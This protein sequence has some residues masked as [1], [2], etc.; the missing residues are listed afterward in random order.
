MIVEFYLAPIYLLSVFRTRGIE[1]H[2]SCPKTLEQSGVVKQK[3]RHL[4]K[5]N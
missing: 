1:L 3:H 5:Y 2:L 4:L